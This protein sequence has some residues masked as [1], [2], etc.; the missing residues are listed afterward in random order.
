MVSEKKNKIRLLFTSYSCYRLSEAFDRCTRF[1]HSASAKQH[2]F[3]A[4]CS[5]LADEGNHAVSIPVFRTVVMSH[6]P[7]RGQVSVWR[8]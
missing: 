8:L 6:F 1:A 3:F 2:R 5:F 4:K 7:W